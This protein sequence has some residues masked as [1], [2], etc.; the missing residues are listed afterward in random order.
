MDLKLTIFYLYINENGIT[1]NRGSRSYSG[2]TSTFEAALRDEAL[3]GDCPR[4]LKEQSKQ[5]T[6]AAFGKMKTK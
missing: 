6:Q 2:I 3:V 5:M 4:L 1:Q